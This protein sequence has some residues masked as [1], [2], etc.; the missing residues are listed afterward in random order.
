[1]LISQELAAAINAEIGREFHASHQY[2]AIAAHFDGLALRKL[3]E[4]FYKQS[5]EERQHAM[6][7]ARYL[8]GVGGA[9][10]VPAV[11]A[12]RAEF[13]SSDE[14]LQLAYHWEL[15]ITRHINDLMTL[16]IEQKDYIAQDFLRWFVSEQLEE[17]RKMDDLLK[18]LRQVGE[19]NLVMVE[20][21][22]VHGEA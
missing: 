9:L 16:A 11:E 5:D 19:R 2:V 6:K 21:Y 17:V 13:E 12:P 3:A 1:M 10:V 14:V 8:V 7:L 22:L 15:E 4:F 18:I 20:A